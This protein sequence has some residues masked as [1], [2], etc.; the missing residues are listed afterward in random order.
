MKRIL[1][2]LPIVALLFV[3][4]ACGTQQTDVDLIEQDTLSLQQDT[5]LLD[6]LDTATPVDTTV[7]DVQP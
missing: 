7:V 2:Y 4:T 3:F 6:T 5:V 1:N